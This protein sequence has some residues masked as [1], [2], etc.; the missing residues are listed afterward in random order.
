MYCLNT[1]CC[2]TG[3]W[4]EYAPTNEDEDWHPRFVESCAQNAIVDDLFSLIDNPQEHDY[5]YPEW[6]K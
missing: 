2:S 6:K 5:F 1:G 3:G 4:R